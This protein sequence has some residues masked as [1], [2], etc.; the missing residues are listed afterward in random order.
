MVATS[1][2]GSAWICLFKDL[3]GNL[4]IDIKSDADTP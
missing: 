1:A 4:V 3:K 2:F